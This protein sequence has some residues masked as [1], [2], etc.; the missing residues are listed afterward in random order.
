MKSG[1]TITTAIAIDRVL[2]L[3]FPLL[4]YQRSKRYWSIGAFVLAIFL[5]FVDWVVL[6]L[7][8]TIRSLPYCSSFA[9][10]TNDVFRA[11]WGLSNMMMN[12]LSCLLTMAIMIRLCKGSVTAC[13][14]RVSLY[15]LL[16]SALMGVVPG[17]LNGLGTIV[18]LPILDEIAFFVGICAT[19]SGLSHAFIF[20]MAHREIRHAILKKFF[21]RNVETISSRVDPEYVGPGNLL[22]TVRAPSLATVRK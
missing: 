16:V 21:R 3:Y 19:L 17:C 5:A 14:N 1:C 2:A 9:C 12:L 7:T 18:T 10:L 20:A 4:Y 6:Q 15:I 13:A 22:T 11:Y 8:V